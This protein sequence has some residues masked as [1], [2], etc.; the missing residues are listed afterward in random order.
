MAKGIIP[1]LAFAAV[2]V[3]SGCTSSPPQVVRPSGTA[4][5]A[6]S[7][8]SVAS[9]APL[10]VSPSISPSPTVYALAPIPAGTARCHTSQLEVALLGAGAA[11]GN[12]RNSFEMRNRSSAPCWVYGYVGFQLLE[13]HG[14][15]LPQSLS[16]TT[17][18]FFGQSDP[19]TRILLPPATPP[20]HSRAAGHAFF[21]VASEDVTCN[22]N[23]MS[24]VANLEIWPPDE[25][26]ALVI[27]AHG[28]DWS[29]GFI[30]C[31]DLTVN[32]MQIRP[33]LS[34]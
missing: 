13:A 10:D 34:G 27:P 19:P 18:S 22:S 15:A 31:G 5:P 24:A 20:L 16:R 23:Q 17:Y 26:A 8:G 7:A 2:L 14:R 12:V 21:E 4:S 32:P 29:G 28:G 3:V 9:V 1:G 6:T 33:G 25:Y 11:T 30:S